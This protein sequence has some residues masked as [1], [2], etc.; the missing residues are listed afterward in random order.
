M[1]DAKTRNGFGDCD[2]EMKAIQSSEDKLSK[3][4]TAAGMGM[5]VGI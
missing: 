5:D 4:T 2:C 3:R 1:N